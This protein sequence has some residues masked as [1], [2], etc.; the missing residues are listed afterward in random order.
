MIV[1]R[2]QLAGL[3]FGAATPAATGPDACEGGTWEEFCDCKYGSNTALRLKCK[4]KPWSCC[5]FGFCPPWAAPSTAV[6][7]ACR[8]LP[9][10]EGAG[11]AYDA[12]YAIQSGLSI[13]S[14]IDKIAVPMQQKGI[15]AQEAEV[16]A[17]QLA[18]IKQQQAVAK[19]QATRAK[20][21]NVMKWS[22]Y[23]AAGIATV[24]ILAEVFAGSSNKVK[25]S[26]R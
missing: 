12:A 8:G 3:G 17:Q 20:V 26:A 7:A 24:V 11:A 4:S 6:G 10:V 25:R 1:S 5:P 18:V 16:V 21:V 13:I 9:K 22:A 19:S 15:A 23:G 14:L 2:S